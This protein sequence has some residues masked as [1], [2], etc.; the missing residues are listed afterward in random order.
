MTLGHDGKITSR[1]LTFQAEMK[2]YDTRHVTV[3]DTVGDTFS[4][5]KR[6]E[7]I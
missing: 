7:N 6:I 2:L 1:F 3:Y 5:L 4:N